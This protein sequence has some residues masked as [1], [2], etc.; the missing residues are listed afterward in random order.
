[1]DREGAKSD[2]ILFIVE[3]KKAEAKY[4]KAIYEY[5]YPYQYVVINR[6]KHSQILSDQGKSV[7]DI[8]WIEDANVSNSLMNLKQMNIALIFQ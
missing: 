8:N 5:Y 2:N 4:I 3:G 1:M 6:E 7:I